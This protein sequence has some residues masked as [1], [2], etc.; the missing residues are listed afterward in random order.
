MIGAAVARLIGVIEEENGALQGNSI[1]SHAGFT[2]RK[3]QCLRELMLAQRREKVEVSDS[4]LRAQ[5]QCLAGL[6]Q[7]NSTLLKNHITAVGEVSDIIV[8]GLKGA[9]SDGTYSRGSSFARWR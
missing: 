7:A 9:E 5:L 8:A 1:T 6:L 3:N 2:D 4:E